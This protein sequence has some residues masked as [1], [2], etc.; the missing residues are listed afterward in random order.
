MRIVLI[1]TSNLFDVFKM[2]ILYYWYCTLILCELKYFLCVT[3]MYF[4]L[5]YR[6]FMCVQTSLLCQFIITFLTL[7]FYLCVYPADVWW[8]CSSVQPGNHIPHMDISYPSGLT[9][10]V[11]RDGTSVKPGNHNP[12]MDTSYPCGLTADV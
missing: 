10:D 8:D 12:H 1:L 11:W 7:V 9:A 3:Q 4:Y 5:M 6:L 2:L